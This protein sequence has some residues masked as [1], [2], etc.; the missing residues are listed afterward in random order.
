[1]IESLATFLV[2]DRHWLDQSDTLNQVEYLNEAFQRLILRFILENRSKEFMDLPVD[3]KLRSV[4]PVPQS[5]KHSTTTLQARNAE[6]TRKRPSPQPSIE[7]G[8]SK[9]PCLD[10]DVAEVDCCYS[11]IIDI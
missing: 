2:V 10:P 4:E 1:M 3:S 9:R 5:E 6:E 8:G 7:E 11:L